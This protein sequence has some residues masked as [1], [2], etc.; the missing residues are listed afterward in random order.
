MS[1]SEAEVPTTGKTKRVDETATESKKKAK[2]NL[3]EEA[4]F[5]I[6]TKRK[7]TVSVFKGQV[8]V[9]IREFYTDNKTGEEKP[10]SKGIAL[11]ADQ[12]RSLC[13]QIDSIKDAVEDRSS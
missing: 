3:L 8:L 2:P 9:N 11:T 4:V 5:A 7:V 13:D 6:G 1:D 10:G 12:W